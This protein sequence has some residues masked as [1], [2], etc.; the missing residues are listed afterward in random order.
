MADPRVA[1]LADVLVNYS[2]QVKKNETVVIQ[3]VGVETVP[4]I[5]EL[6]K[7][8]VKKG[9]KEV[10]YRLAIPDVDRD[11]YL[12]ANKNQLEYFPQHEMNFMKETDVFI[13]VRAQ[14]NSMTYAN[15]DG[16]KMNLHGKTTYPILNER[17]NNTRW[18][19]TRFPTQSAAQE[20]G[21]SLEEFEDFFFACTIYD[22]KALKKRQAKL[23]SL[24][25]K[26]KQVHIKSS[27]TD[28]RF[29]IEGLPAISCHGDKNIPDGEVYTAPVR[30]SVEGY[31]K[32]NAPS[33]YQGKEFNNVY[34]E[35]KEGKI[36]KADAGA[37]TKAINDIF[38]TDEGARYVGEFAIGTNTSITKPMKNILFDEKIFGSFHFT[39]GMAYDDCDNGNRSAVHWDLVKLLTGDGEIWFDGKLIQKNGIFVHPSLTALNPEGTKLPK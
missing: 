3:C 27:D 15:V 10:V 5:K 23:A 22:Y 30:N 4:I 28:L 7:L 6:H 29:S 35:F 39:P 2:T 21:M 19:V 20:A 25:T 13:G 26:T 38:N 9:A 11:F 16:K 31:I 37:L 1:E 34:L 14:D 18:V 12:Y 17:V 24:M 32:Y 8:C 36:V 33:V